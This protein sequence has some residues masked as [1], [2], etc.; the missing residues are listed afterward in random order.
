MTPC[1]GQSIPTGGGLHRAAPCLFHSDCLRSKESR[2]A[3]GKAGVSPAFSVSGE[4]E[5]VGAV[6]EGGAAVGHDDD[7]AV[8]P[9]GG[10]QAVEQFALGVRV[11]R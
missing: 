7:G 1:S 2:R 11:E 6:G 5:D 4:A 10:A 3:T 9:Q 8:G